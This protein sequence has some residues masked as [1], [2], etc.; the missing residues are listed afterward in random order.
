MS[1]PVVFDR[2][3]FLKL[4]GVGVAGVS[5]GCAA[6]PADKLIPYLI[7]PEDILPR[8]SLSRSSRRTEPA[9]SAES[10]GVRK[11]S[12]PSTRHSGVPP[13]F[14]ATQG[15]PADNASQTASPW[16]SV[17]DGQTKTSAAA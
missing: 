17:M 8:R 3:D 9:N 1:D 2:R 14:T 11:L 4:V 5:A 13:P 16:V 10:F 7:A 12:T 15:S 6:P